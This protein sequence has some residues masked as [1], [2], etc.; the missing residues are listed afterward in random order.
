[1][2]LAQIEYAAFVGGMLLA[3]KGK[4]SLLFDLGPKYDDMLTA[5]LRNR[6]C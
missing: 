2:A 1:M 5:Y 6:Q 4:S 3:S